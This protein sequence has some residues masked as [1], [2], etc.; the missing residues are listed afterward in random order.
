MNSVQK[1]ETS[2]WLARFI[3][4]VRHQYHLVRQKRAAKKLG[5][6]LV[7]A[8]S[9]LEAMRRFS[10]KVFAYDGPREVV[11]LGTERPD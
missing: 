11:D 2:M 1:G 8:G 5:F 10:D 3:R 6:E 4:F 7:F 9:D